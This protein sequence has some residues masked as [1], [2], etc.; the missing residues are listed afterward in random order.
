MRLGLNA[1]IRARSTEAKTEHLFLNKQ[2]CPITANGVERRVNLF[3]QRVGVKITPHMLR[4]TFAKNALDHGA[5][6]I[7][8]AT[9]LGHENLNTTRRY[10]TPGK[11]DLEKVVETL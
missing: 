8:V 5:D 1:W 4:H 3:A 7:Q 11:D 6:L 2:G 10:L 9:L